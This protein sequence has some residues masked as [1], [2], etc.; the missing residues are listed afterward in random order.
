MFL[1]CLLTASALPP[2]PSHHDDA[3]S[4]ATPTRLLDAA[5][6]AIRR[7][8]KHNA[9][10]PS[11]DSQ[12]S[13]QTLFLEAADDVRQLEPAARCAP[14]L[15]RMRLRAARLEQA[16]LPLQISSQSTNSLSDELAP[17]LRVA[18]RLLSNLNQKTGK[19]CARG[20]FS[21]H[22]SSKCNNYFF[23]GID[24]SISSVNA[25]AAFTQA[26]RSTS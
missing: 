10:H 25:S 7:G 1:G 24:A 26:A 18:F 16:K 15:G 4:G 5:D 8:P 11:G 23:T 21:A 9:R 17:D 2:A 12:K 22:Q 13:T 3:P 19:S 14:Q 20:S 6:A